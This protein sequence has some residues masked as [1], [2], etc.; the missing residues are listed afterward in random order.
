M[1]QFSPNR[2]RIKCCNCR[3]TDVISNVEI[4][5][6]ST[7]DKMLQFSQKIEILSFLTSTVGG[8]ENFDN[9]EMHFL[10]SEKMQSIKLR[11]FALAEERNINARYNL[12]IDDVRR[13]HV[14]VHEGGNPGVERPAVREP[15]RDAGPLQPGEA[16]HVPG[17]LKMP[18]FDEIEITKNKNP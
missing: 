11:P 18:R 14:P 7:P 4:V 15:R 9:V 3:G 12:G 1:L 2:L 17:M 5:V 10:Y 6:E 16:Q 13:D 8:E